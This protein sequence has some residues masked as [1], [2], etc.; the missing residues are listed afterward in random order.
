MQSKLKCGARHLIQV[1]VIAALVGAGSLSS[2]VAAQAGSNNDIAAQAANEALQT[3]HEN[4]K[5]MAPPVEGCF[6][7]TY[8][9]VIWEREACASAPKFRSAPNAA[10]AA[11]AAAATKSFA[12][13]RIANTSRAADTAGDGTDYAAE[14]ANLTKSAVG[15]FPAVTVKGVKSGNGYTLQLNTNIS[16]TSAAELSPVCASYGYDSCTTWEQ[17]IYSTDYPEASGKVPAG[18]QAFIQNWLFIP[19]DATCPSGWENFS[20]SSYNGCYRNSAAVAVANVP[21][22]KLATVKLAGSAS[23]S[24]LDTVTFTYAGVAHAV[25]QKGSTLDIGA[26][27]KQSEFNIVGNGGGSGF[28]FTKGS[29][30]TVKLAVNDGG[31]KAPTCLANAGTTGETNNLNL[32]KCTASGGATPSIQ[33]TE[34]N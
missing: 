17:F 34:S 6:R 12:N 30:L 9:S 20:T 26:T 5:T 28:T 27:W 8:P 15:T 1:A 21:A 14:T 29:S 13:A 2:A 31:T 23:T 24:G 16:G 11:A 18:P 25:S 3:W 32:G 33:F 19:T 22:A 7:A 4:I 10:V